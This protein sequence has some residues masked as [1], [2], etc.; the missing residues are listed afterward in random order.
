MAP[1]EKGEAGHADTGHMSCEQ[2]VLAVAGSTIENQGIT[3]EG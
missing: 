3:V 2:M 1:A